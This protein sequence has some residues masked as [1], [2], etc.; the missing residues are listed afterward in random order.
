MISKEKRSQYWDHF[1]SNAHRRFRPKKITDVRLKQIKNS[2]LDN[3]QI[4]ENFSLQND[5][6]DQTPD[7]LKKCLPR[8]YKKARVD[9]W[10][11][12]REQ[13]QSQIV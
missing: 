13:I 2:V 12:I 1:T 11:M 5:F 9:F 3:D 10:S 8:D 6:L 7:E 4:W